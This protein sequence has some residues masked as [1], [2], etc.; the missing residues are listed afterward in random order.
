M[1]LESGSAERT[2][3]GKPNKKTYLE[4]GLSNSSQKAI[5]DYLEGEK[6]RALHFEYGM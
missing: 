5:K 3:A 1:E 2:R 4:T 6:E